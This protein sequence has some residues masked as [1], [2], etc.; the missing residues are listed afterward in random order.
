MVGSSGSARAG[1]ETLALRPQV[2]GWRGSAKGGNGGQSL[3][4]EA[5]WWQDREVVG[6]RVPL[7]MI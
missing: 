3:S 5:H 2:G 6:P 1:M 7:L 4:T